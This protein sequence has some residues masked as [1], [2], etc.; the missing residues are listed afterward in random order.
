MNGKRETFGSRFAVIMAM[1]GSAIGLGN[2]WR[3]PYMTG[4]YGG[5]AFIIVY[6]FASVFLSLPILLSETIIGR[7]TQSGTFGAMQKLAPGTNW[8]WM[9]LLTVISPMIL[10][11]YYSVVGGWS[12]EYFCKALTFSFSPAITG[13]GGSGTSAISAAASSAGADNVLT[14]FGNF[15]SEPAGPVICH[16]LFLALTALIVLGG[17]KKGIEK[18]ST[19]TMPILFVLIVVIMLYALT[20]PGAEKGVEYMVR[21]DF[22]KLTPMAI[23]SAVGQSFFSLSLGVG[24]MLTY[25]SY[26]PKRDN[27]LTSGIGTAGFD[28]LFALLAGFAVMPA[29]FSAGIAPASGPGLVFETLPY[30]FVKMSAAS[31]WLSFIVAILFFFTIL[32]AA[33]TSSISMLEVGVAYLVEEKRLSRRKAVVVLFVF[34]WVLGTICSL[35]F[36]PLSGFKIFG[37]TIFSFCDRLVSIFLMTFGGLLFTIFVGWK[38]KRAD[39]RDEFTS[40]GTQKFNVKCFNLVYFLIRYVAPVVIG[41]IF[42]TNLITN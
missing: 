1:A 28:L 12:I 37:N 35:S 16:S 14:M 30:I 22:S 13:G 33:L 2:I 26:I 6:L 27:L 4:Q 17:V 42:I 18:F 25:A 39:V 41:V 8:K 29:V 36:G 11:S 3:F 19:I 20:L 24:T 32:V 40:G 23:A 5:A 7:R 9:G 31:P 34:C 38:M 21:P 10:L 15:I